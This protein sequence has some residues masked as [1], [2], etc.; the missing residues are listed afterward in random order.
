MFLVFVGLIIGGMIVFSKC[1]KA[2]ASP[3]GVWVCL[4]TTEKTLEPDY[5]CDAFGRSRSKARAKEKA[6]DNCWDKCHAECVV[7]ACAR[8]K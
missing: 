8:R 1:H 2:E 3:P 4:A 5:D 7:N 6:I